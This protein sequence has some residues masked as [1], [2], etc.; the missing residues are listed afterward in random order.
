MR[1]YGLFAQCVARDIGAA[2]ITLE[3]DVEALDAKQNSFTVYVEY[4]DFISKSAKAA[5]CPSIIWLADFDC[6][7]S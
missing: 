1:L 5:A 2:V 6:E 7:N 3:R 4:S